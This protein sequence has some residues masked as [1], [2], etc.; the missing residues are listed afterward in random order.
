MSEKTYQKIGCI[1]ANQ[2]EMAQEAFAELSKRYDLIDIENGNSN[3]VDVIVALGGDGFMLHILHRYFDLNIPVYGMNCGTVGF[4]M[5]AYSDNDLLERIHEAKPA[6]LHPLKMVATTEDGKKHEKFAMNEV[7]LLRSTNQAAKI[8]ISIDDT[9]QMEELVCDGVLV[10]TP[11]G[12]SAYNL[13]VGGPIVPVRSNVLALTP[14]SPFRPKRWHGALLSHN[15]EITFDILY[16]D[17]RCVN[18]VADFN[19]VACVKQVVVTE[20]RDESFTLLFDRH[21][22]LEQRILKEQFVV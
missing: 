8:R 10:A 14:I 20:N 6:T 15:A 3:D 4:L 2:S 12:S 11:A 17:K 9:V 1:A 7:S 19:E 5:N 13:S 22:S 16:P 21:H 18:A